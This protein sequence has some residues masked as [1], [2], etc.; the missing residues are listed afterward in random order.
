MKRFVLHPG[1]VVSRSDGDVHFISAP[2]LETLYG[3]DR[4]ECIVAKKGMDA[5][6]HERYYGPDMIHLYPRDDGRYPTMK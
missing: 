2:M 3:V 4:R 5:P 1:E 6:H